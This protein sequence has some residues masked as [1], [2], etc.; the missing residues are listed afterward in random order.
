MEAVVVLAAGDGQRVQLVAQAA[1]AV[2]VVPRQRLLE[3]P[4]LHPLELA[5]H[6]Q[7]RRESPAVVSAVARL[8][9]GL[10]RVDHDLDAIADRSAHSFD[11]LQVVPR[12]GEMKS[13]LDRFVAFGQHPLHVVDAL[14]GRAD[15]GGRAVRDD[16]VGKAAPQP[17][18]G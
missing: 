16:A 1:E 11:D 15:L 9:P 6:R 12:V 13:K 17:R 7:R 2:V 5:R 18:D 4:H 10:V 3:P 14:R 8:D